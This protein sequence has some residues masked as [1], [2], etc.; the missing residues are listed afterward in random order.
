MVNLRKRELRHAGNERH[1][2]GPKKLAHAA[3]PQRIVARVSLLDPYQ[4]DPG[5][6]A[7]TLSE[8]L[9]A[10]MTAVWTNPAAARPNPQ[11]E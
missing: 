9:Q 8:D 2:Q 7:A 1:L 5:T 4:P 11:S 10:R 6:A 3:R